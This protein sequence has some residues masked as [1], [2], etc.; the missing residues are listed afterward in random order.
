MLVA[1]GTAARARDVRAVTRVKADVQEQRAQRVVVRL[2]AV[3]A[4]AQLE[5][6]SVYE[7]GVGVQLPDG[8]RAV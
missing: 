4:D 5:R 1:S 6:E 7:F 2:R 8:H 3:G